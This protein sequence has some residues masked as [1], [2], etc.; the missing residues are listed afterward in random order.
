MKKIQTLMLMLLVA[1]MGMTV[2]SC[3]DDDNSTSGD[4][5][6][7]YIREDFSKTLKFQDR[8]ISEYSDEATVKKLSED[9]QM[10]LL[11][12]FTAIKEADASLQTLVDGGTTPADAKVISTYKKYVEEFTN[13]KG[14]E[15]TIKIT[16]VKNGTTSEVGTITFTK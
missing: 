7:G 6:V 3:G 15:G 16:K 11:A 2:Q 12:F 8:Y 10:T 14:F 1:V 13:N 5:K 9:Q 4:N